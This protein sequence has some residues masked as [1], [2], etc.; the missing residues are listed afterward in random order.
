[1]HSP[2]SS[3]P[4]WRAA[5][6]WLA[7]AAAAALA[8]GCATRAAD[9]QPAPAD[10]ADFLPWSCARIHD[11]ID[12]V[13]HRAVEVAWDIDQRVGQH[14]VALG[15]GL[16]VFWPAL[17][18]MQP[19]GLEADALAHL[20][21]RFEALKLAA[22]HKGCAS[23]PDVL[24]PERAAMLPVRPGERLIYE[25][26][27]GVREPLTELALTMTALRRNEIDFVLEADGPAGRWRQ[28]LAGN[29]IEAPRGALLW[30]R[31]LE[32]PLVLGDVLAGG[33]HVSG[34][35]VLRAR[36]RGQVVAVGPQRIGGRSFDA[37]VVELFGDVPH[38]ETSTRLEG[39]IVVDRNSGVLLRLDLRSAQPVF[40]LQRRLVRVEPLG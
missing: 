39:A 16:A 11:E 10:P 12:L 15:V 4:R 40:R 7:V 23:P 3:P 22:R 32:H 31:L 30:Q 35:P 37:A 9:V 24:A 14:V 5:A 38:G 27:R 26:S 29:V 25:E 36:V 19:D 21:G 2:P 28:D 33:I 8:A 17:L 1:M 13:Q 18:A 20:K 6:R 34:D